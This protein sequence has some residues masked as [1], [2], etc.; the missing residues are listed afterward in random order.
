MQRA[1]GRSWANLRVAATRCSLLETVVADDLLEG[2]QR[3]VDVVELLEIAEAIGF[4]P[5]EAIRRLRTV[6]K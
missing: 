2:G 6:R 4:D 1:C 3:R 5:T